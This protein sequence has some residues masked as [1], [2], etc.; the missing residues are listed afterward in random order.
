MLNKFIVLLVYIS[1]NAIYYFSGYTGYSPIDFTVAETYF[2]GLQKKSY[3][4]RF[5]VCEIVIYIIQY[6]KMK[7]KKCFLLALFETEF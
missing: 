7:N 4:T 6:N 2:N 3:G 5:S 1:K